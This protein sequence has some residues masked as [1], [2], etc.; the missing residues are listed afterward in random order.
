[1]HHE[2]K[3]GQISGDWGRHP[4]TYALLQRDGNQQ[5]TKLTWAKTRWATLEPEE[6]VV[7]L[8]WVIEGQGYN[9]IAIELPVTD[10][11]LDDRI[12]VYLTAHPWSS[13]RTVQ[14]NVKGN[15][16]RISERLKVRFDSAPGPRGATLWGP[17]AEDAE[18]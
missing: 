16:G 13:T 6:K 1:M 12:A 2:N 17:A 3:Q 11:D 14:K 18:T 7:V 15:D 10:D 8:E 4:D 9:V 5:R